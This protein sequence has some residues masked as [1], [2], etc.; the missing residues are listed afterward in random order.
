MSVAKK[1]LTK[2]DLE[3]HAIVLNDE[4]SR[5][6]HQRGVFPSL[7]GNNLYV[8]AVKVFLLNTN[9]DLL[10]SYYASLRKQDR[11]VEERMWSSAF[12]EHADVG[13]ELTIEFKGGRFVAEIR[14][15]P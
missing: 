10:V 3:K 1:I 8:N 2:T 9:E 4:L 15:A 11:P 6:F 13:D 12:A 14:P 7:G 5:L